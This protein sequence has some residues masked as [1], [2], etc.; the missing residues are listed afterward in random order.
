MCVCVSDCHDSSCNIIIVY[1]IIMHSI[2]LLLLLCMCYAV[3]LCA[4]LVNWDMA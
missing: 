3:Q 2:V 1:I 4:W